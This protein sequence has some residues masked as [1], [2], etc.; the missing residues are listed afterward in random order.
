MHVERA[1]S[2][3]NLL[4]VPPAKRKFWPQTSV[5]VLDDAS[6]AILDVVPVHGSPLKTA[7]RLRPLYPSALMFP[8][9]VGE[10][11]SVESLTARISQCFDTSGVPYEVWSSTLDS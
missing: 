2:A 4:D 9:R 10:F 5:V 3:V 7:Q 11:V 6:R 8:A 1:F